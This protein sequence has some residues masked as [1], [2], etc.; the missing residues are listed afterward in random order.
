[1]DDDTDLRMDEAE[2]A[3]ALES[4]FPGVGWLAD[5]EIELRTDGWTGPKGE[6]S[7]ADWL[8]SCL[9]DVFSNNHDVIAPDGR[10]ADL[11]SFRGSGGTIAAF[12]ERRVAGARYEYMDFYMGTFGAKDAHAVAPIHRLIFR[13]LRD[14]G[15]DWRY[16]FPRLFVVS[17]PRLER[18]DDPSHP[19]WKPYAPDD[20]IARETEEQKRRTE[21]DE[22][23]AT[24]E[25]G[26]RDDLDRA[27]REPPPAIVTAFRTAYGR[28]PRGWPPWED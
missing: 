23:E 22:F 20:T 18:V 28:D 25:R 9:W 10:I 11:G 7:L 8:G 14:R 19:D 4:L 12:L 1:M 24:L 13:R 6:A 3:A 26:Y 16:A 15:F 2:A 17:F 27:R 5:V 21:H